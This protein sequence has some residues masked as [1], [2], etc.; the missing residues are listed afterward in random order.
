MEIYPGAVMKPAGEQAAVGALL[1]VGIA[2]FAV[3][4]FVGGADP[5]GFG[6]GIGDGECGSVG[7]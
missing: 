4:A 7:R 6:A 5:G 1:D 3:G 2:G